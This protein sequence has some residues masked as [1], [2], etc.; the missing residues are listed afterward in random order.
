MNKYA[1]VCR[2]TRFPSDDD[3]KDDNGDDDDDEI[4]D[5]TVGVTSEDDGYRKEI[6]IGVAST[7]AS[8]A[9]IGVTKKYCPSRPSQ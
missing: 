1:T 5:A 4:T 7:L 6:V 9:I 3:G 8:A 2:R